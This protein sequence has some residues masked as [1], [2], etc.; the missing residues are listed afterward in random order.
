[1]VGWLTGLIYLLGT[2]FV[3]RDELT[4]GPDGNDGVADRVTKEE[5][6]EDTTGADRVH[7]EIHKDEDPLYKE[8]TKWTC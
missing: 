2:L 7:V 1:M 5:V 3:G 8:W 6:L 4:Q